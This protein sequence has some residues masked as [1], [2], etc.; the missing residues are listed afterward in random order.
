MKGA[1]AD[2]LVSTTKPPK[3]S[4]KRMIGRSQNFFRNLRNPQRSLKKSIFSILFGGLKPIADQAALIRFFR[5][6]RR[7]R[8]CRSGGLGINAAGSSVTK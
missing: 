4:R 7:Q 8:G 1:M 5:T 3:R 2:P 6:F